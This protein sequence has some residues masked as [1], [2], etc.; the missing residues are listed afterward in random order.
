MPPS[1]DAMKTFLPMRAIEH[2]AEVQFALDGQRL[3]DQHLLHDA[4]FGSGLVRDQR[5]AENFC[6]DLARFGCVFGDLYA[7]A[8]ASAAGVNLR[9]HY[10]AAADLSSPPLR[11]LR[12]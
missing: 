2:D 5:H 11:L 8:F 6:G 10:H 7:A 12:Q 3:F 4:A 9:L 1:D